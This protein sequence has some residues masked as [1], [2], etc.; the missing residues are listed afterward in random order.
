MNNEII[1]MIT[2]EDIIE[3]C[4]EAFDNIIDVATTFMRSRTD[5]TGSKEENQTQDTSNSGV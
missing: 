3:C 1:F 4:K 2:S 5:A